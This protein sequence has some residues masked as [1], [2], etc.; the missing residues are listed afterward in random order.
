[1]N[2]AKNF[3]TFQ[4]KIYSRKL[5]NIVLNSVHHNFL[6][7][8]RYTKIELSSRVSHTIFQF[9]FSLNKSFRKCGKW[10][11]RGD[12]NYAHIQL[13]KLQLSFCAGF[14]VWIIFIDQ[15]LW[16]FA[17]NTCS[18]PAACVTESCYA[19]MRDCWKII[20]TD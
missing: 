2:S 15:N 11:S 8:T 18:A 10:F 13:N 1:L 5:V 3:K 20:E 17:S 7:E 19:R 6:D 14:Y 12:D 4:T 9:R 16:T